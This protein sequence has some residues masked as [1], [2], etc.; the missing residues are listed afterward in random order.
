M[1]FRMS[2]QTDSEEANNLQK[3]LQVSDDLTIQLNFNGDRSIKLVPKYGKTFF[4]SNNCSK[5][6]LEYRYIK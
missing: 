3:R 6:I 2:Q 4:I 5:F 1:Q